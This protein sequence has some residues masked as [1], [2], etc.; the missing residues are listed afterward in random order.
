MLETIKTMFEGWGVGPVTALWLGRLVLVVGVSIVSWL[1][2]LLG[3]QVVLRMLERVVE[4]TQTKWDDVLMERGVFDR[5]SHLAPA[6]VIYVLSGSMFPQ[7]E[8][9]RRF[10]EQ[11]A[12]A[13]MFVVAALVVN[14][15]LYAVLD[16][17][18]TFELAKTRPIR[19]YIQVIR[20][21]LFIITA[22]FVL[23]TVMSRSPWAFLSGFGALTAVIM[24][25]FKD[26]ILGF[27]ASIQLAA[28]DM[29]R[30]GDWI[31]MP[32]Y[33]ADG[34]VLDVSINAIKIQNW[35][36]TISTVPTYALVTDSF[37][38]WRGMSESGGRRIKRSI[39]L[40]VGS[41]RFSDDAMLERLRA[42]P[43]LAEAFAALDARDGAGSSA[44]P[45][46]RRVTNVGLFRAYLRAL[47]R[48][49]PDIHQELT[50]LVRD[51]APGPEGLPIEVYVFSSDQVWAHYERI[52]SELFEHIVAVLPEF[53]LR[54][55]QRP[56]GEDMRAGLAGQPGLAG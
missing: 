7:W 32:K 9:A 20:I 6:F 42:E 36:K 14:A 50:F 26:S 18:Q 19:S 8:A 2:N 30:P 10:V 53:G 38:N 56:S 54:V 15:F 48:A 34:D 27:V 3:K 40:D 24:L 41:V 37:K 44:V 33:G 12:T 23:A 1:A 22:V 4:K 16:I 51:L 35:D 43:L 52:Q 29:V 55:F 46:L 28:N 47:L 17:Y 31:E 5:L 39:H 45:A 11:G 49:H 13:Y 25:V 21:V